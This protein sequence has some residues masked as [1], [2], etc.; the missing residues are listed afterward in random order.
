MHLS[1][2]VANAYTNFVKSNPRSSNL[3]VMT[4]HNTRNME[5]A[6]DNDFMTPQADNATSAK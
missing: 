2:H 3:K 1:Q 4:Q 6:A 5:F